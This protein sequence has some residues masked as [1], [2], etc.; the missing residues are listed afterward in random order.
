VPPV[1][2]FRSRSRSRTDVS[3]TTRAT[4]TAGGSTRV[5]T[6][7][8]GRVIEGLIPEPEVLGVSRRKADGKVRERTGATVDDGPIVKSA[9]ML[10]KTTRGYTRRTA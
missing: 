6:P 8:D 10:R 5:T 2:F 4:R 3:H 7:D 1:E 9:W